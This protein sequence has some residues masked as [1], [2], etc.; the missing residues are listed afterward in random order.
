MIRWILPL[1]A[2]LF[3]L[4]CSDVANTPSSTIK[5]FFDAQAKG[6]MV[7]AKGACGKEFYHAW[8]EANLDAVQDESKMFAFDKAH[9]KTE[10]ESLKRLESKLAEHLKTKPARLLYMVREA[11]P[12]PHVRIVTIQLDDVVYYVSLRETEGFWK[13]IMMEKGF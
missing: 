1:L 3:F 7:A 6:D 4:G 12:E 13:I 11:A 2:A 5:S 10:P 8:I 9:F